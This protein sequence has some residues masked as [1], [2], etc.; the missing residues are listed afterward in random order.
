MRQLT[1]RTASEPPDQPPDQDDGRNPGALRHSRLA[2]ISAAATALLRRHRRKATFAGVGSTCFAVQYL[3]L[4][5]LMV[6]GVRAPIANAVGIAISAQLNFTLSS[7]LTWKD[8]PSG[9]P[10]RILTRLLAYNATALTA[11]CANTAIFTLTYRT[12]GISTA[13]AAGVAAGMLFN[14]AGSNHLVFR[15][16]SRT[17]HGELES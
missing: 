8:R 17:P 16:A 5:S 3:L 10:R 15:G 11:L 1:Y 9:S 2:T 12:T 14:Y 13:A 6:L 7:L 4:T